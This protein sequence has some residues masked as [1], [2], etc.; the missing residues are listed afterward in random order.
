MRMV[1]HSRGQRQPDAG[2]HGVMHA[3]SNRR[4]EVERLGHIRE[5][6]FG[7]QDGLLTTIGVV[8]GVSGA[9][10]HSYTILVAGLAEAAAGMVAMGAGEFISARSQ[11]QVYE[12][13]IDAERREVEHNP[14]EEQREVRALFQAEGL[15][16]H[17]ADTVAHLIST[18]RD[19]WLKTMVEKELGIASADTSGA[20]KG[21]VVMGITFL[22]GAAVPILPYVFLPVRAA[23]GLSVV[24]TL[25]VL[26][27]MGAGKARI[28]R[29][30]PL[31]SALETVAIGSFAATFGYLVGTLL[32][33]ILHAG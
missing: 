32:P 15:S 33:H 6:I 4:S 19:S 16:E 20:L 13:E 31:K 11:A 14:L 7:I 2:T 12:A 1:T 30:S 23:L 5:L 9:T 29:V 10:A 17:A 21:A 22:A 27:A 25:V 24:L 8:T 18:S 28:A 26:A 3:M